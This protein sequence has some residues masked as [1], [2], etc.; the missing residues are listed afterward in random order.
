MQF[1]VDSTEISDIKEA[2]ALGLCDGVTTNPS[3]I[4]KSGRALKPVIQEIAGLVEGPVLAEVTG[5]AADAIIAEGREIA[6]WAENVVVKIPVTIEGLKAIRALESEDIATGTTLVFSP[7][8]GLL[9][10]KAG[11]RY[12]IPFIGRLD[13]I[14]DAG[15]GLAVQIQEILS[16][17]GFDA[18]VLAA[19]VRNPG[20]V[21]ACAMSGVPVVTA[22][23]NV[24]KQ[25]AG[26]PLTDIG[27]QR[28]L[29]DWESAKTEL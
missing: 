16:N 18:E 8:Q 3:L 7:S 11:T 13:D 17:Y 23:L 12:V 28:F 9:A 27:I 25:M 26:H 19:S 4:A 5:S 24:Y 6:A 21:I 20:H 14:S 29:A 2:L 1:F 22:P 10:A 15:I